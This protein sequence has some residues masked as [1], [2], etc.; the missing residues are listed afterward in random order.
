MLNAKAEELDR[1]VRK[2]TAVREGLRHAAVRR[3]PSHAECPSFQR[4]LRV[5]AKRSRVASK[6]GRRRARA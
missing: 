5:A 6:R 2:L 3:A 4:M 1:T